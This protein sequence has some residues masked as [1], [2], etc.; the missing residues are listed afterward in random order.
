MLHNKYMDHIVRQLEDVRKP[1]KIETKDSKV[2][3]VSILSTKPKRKVSS[4][5]KMSYQLVD[6]FRV[7]SLQNYKLD[8]KLNPIEINI[9]DSKIQGKLSRYFTQHY[10]YHFIVDN[11]L[12]SLSVV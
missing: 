3:N 4:K 11:L 10:K 9:R 1:G 2:I 5:R 8:E 6:E 7:A 12:I